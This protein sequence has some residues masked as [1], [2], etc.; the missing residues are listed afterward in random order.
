MTKYITEVITIVGIEIKLTQ[1]TKI[2]N[3]LTYVSAIIKI[4][5]ATIPVGEFVNKNITKS[6]I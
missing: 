4:F 2:D 5:T 3:Y 6:K 1:K